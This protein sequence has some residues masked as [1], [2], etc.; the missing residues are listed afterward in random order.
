MKRWRH[1]AAGLVSIFALASAL[2]CLAASEPRDRSAGAAHGASFLDLLHALELER[3]PRLGATADWLGHPAT[4]QVSFKLPHVDQV[5]ADPRQLIRFGGHLLH[6]G[7]HS[8]QQPGDIG[9]TT[10]VTVFALQPRLAGFRG[11][12]LSVTTLPAA[13]GVL[14]AV[15]DRLAEVASD[16]PRAPVD[17]TRPSVAPPWP[18]LG[19]EERSLPQGLRRPLAQLLAAILEAGLDVERSWRRLPST[20]V[21][22]A[23]ST[24]EAPRLLAGGTMS[25]PALDDAARLGDDT[26]RAFALT[27][28]LTALLTASR[29]LGQAAAAL[30]G[31]EL[32]QVTTPWGRVVV[33]GRAD[34]VHRCADDCLLIVDL[35]GADVYEGTAAAAIFPDQPLALVLDLA[36]ADHYR[37]VAGKPAQ[38]ASHGGVGMLFDLAGDD[39][40]EADDSAQGFGLLGYGL[41]WDAAGRDRFVA[42]GGAQGAAIFGAGLLIDGGGED[43][44]RVLGEGQGFG[45]PGA[46]GALIDLSGDDRYSAEADP[47]VAIGRADYHSGGRVAANNAQGVGVGRRGDLTDGQAWAG[48]VGVLADLAG[49]DQYVAGNFAQGL[50]YW[51]G[52]GLLL[53]AA[54]D[55]LYRSVYFSQA[56]SAHFG[57][58]LLYDVAGNDRHLLAQEAAASLGYGWDFGL[59]ILVDG[60]GDDLYEAR[61]TSLGVA[62]LSSLAWVLELGGDDTYRLPPGARALGWSAPLHERRSGEPWRSAT[63]ADQVGMFV[64]WSG[65]DAY[66]AV[67]SDGGSPGNG[68]RWLGSPRQRGGALQLGIGVDVEEP[69]LKDLLGWLLAA[70]VGP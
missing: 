20:V 23:T 19:S 37:A 68:R 42:A 39:L 36:G 66:P 64:D 43:S 59:S 38:G 35:G 40:Y 31:D 54:G 61:D 1:V 69:S 46:C 15:L 16:D 70:S 13:D 17:L 60:Q 2:D 44:Y 55:D 47:T 50:G 62:E 5:S 24:R 22:Q 45:G 58:A 52:T 56:S 18:A 65:E 3:V 29:E 10:L 33:A 30:P 26:A 25:W 49:D 32:W 27:R 63:A 11:V 41:L 14:S 8:G 48:G 12:P 4:E 34:H 21:R 28:L 7:L 53:D 51:F 67:A 6:A 57:L 9:L